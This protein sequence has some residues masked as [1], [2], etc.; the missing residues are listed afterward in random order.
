MN[1]Y[2]P[3]TIGKNKQYMEKLWGFL[4]VL[5]QNNLL[6]SWLSWNNLK[7]RCEIF[8]LQNIDDFMFD[9]IFY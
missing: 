2:I 8:S 3:L 5:I 4:H 9:Y 6:A 7:F 1:T